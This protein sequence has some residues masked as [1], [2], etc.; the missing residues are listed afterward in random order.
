MSDAAS[1]LSLSGFQSSLSADGGKAVAP[2]A[3]VT[4][5]G[6][7]SASVVTAVFTEVSGQAGSFGNTGSGTVSSDGKSVTFRGT[8]SAVQKA[9]ADLTWTSSGTILEGITTTASFTVLLSTASGESTSL[10]QTLKVS[11]TEQNVFHSDTKTWV[12]APGT[13]GDTS[14]VTITATAGQAVY[15]GLETLTIRS[16]GATIYLNKP[17]AANAD[18]TSMTGTV[19]GANATVISSGNSTINTGSGIL[20]LYAADGDT[21]NMGESGN[22]P[23]SETLMLKD[24]AQNATVSVNLVASSSTTQSI[25]NLSLY[26]KLVIRVNGGTSLNYT[27]RDALISANSADVTGKITV[28]SSDNTEIWAG[29][30][31][32]YSNVTG[33]TGN[34]IVMN[35]REA[36]VA[37]SDGA[38]VLTDVQAGHANNVAVIGQAGSVHTQ[39]IDTT[40]SL[41]TV[42]VYAGVDNI[43]Y[44]GKNGVLVGNGAGQT[45]SWDVTGVSGA[46]NR[47][48]AG[49]GKVTYHAAG[50][51][52]AILGSVESQGADLEISGG[53]A[54]DKSIVTVLGNST[55]TLSLTQSGDSSLAVFGPGQYMN[56]TAEKGTLTFNTGEAGHD[57]VTSKGSLTVW[58]GNNDLDFTGSSAGSDTLYLTGSGQVTVSEA[59]VSAASGVLTL[60]QFEESTGNMTVS[61][62]ARD[63]SITTSGT[64]QDVITGGSGAM[65]LYAN[66]GGSLLLTLGTGSTDL[67]LNG[68]SSGN[69][70]IYGSGNLNVHEFDVTSVDTTAASTIYHFAN[71]NQATWYGA[72]AASS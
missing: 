37:G 5:T 34:M 12:A 42:N 53:T 8:A 72:A 44:T 61:A 27:G 67:Y 24:I 35:A 18:G 31:T 30:G 41:A 7:E 57:R 20:G 23:S 29:A 25:A 48:W 47:L 40:G 56:I 46:T 58:N 50:A 71:G 26:G 39:K 70:S 59:T 16:S 21:V 6:A 38:L 10:T 65:T 69:V 17:V 28:N 51:L 66:G 19:S 62:G 4:L 2:A 45:S 1:G 11:G 54:S 3:G 60:S 64:G 49:D 36:G 68:S 43:T 22:N 33:T 52:D 9:L 15:S 13:A 32:V 14:D 55:K 63:A